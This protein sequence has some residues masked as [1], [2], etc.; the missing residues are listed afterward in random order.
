MARRYPLSRASKA[1]GFIS[2]NYDEY[3]EPMRKTSSLELKDLVVQKFENDFVST[4]S[5]RLDDA[6]IDMANLRA[7]V[8][9]MVIRDPLMV[10]STDLIWSDLWR[11]CRQVYRIDHKVADDLKNTDLDEEIPADVLLR[12]PYPII[13]IEMPITV[14]NG[15]EQFKTDGF[16]AYQGYDNG[17]RSIGLTYFVKDGGRIHSSIPCSKTISL[18]DAI[19]HKTAI[20]EDDGTISPYRD[21]LENTEEYGCIASQLAETI[22][23]LLYIIAGNDLETV[24]TPPK[25]T[26]PGQKRGRKTNPETVAIAGA[27]MGRAIKST[28]RRASS[29]G[30]SEPT[31]QT[32][33]PHIR[34]AHWAHYWVGPRKDRSDGKPGDRLELKW[35]PPINVNEDHGEV[36]ETIHR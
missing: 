2:S 35:I 17:I 19:A 7:E 16:L 12:I 31:G 27:K 6:Q 25:T 11:S 33:A 24:Y 20:V 22:N 34:A 15:T 3:L 9:K 28:K 29:R 23:A 5:H 8:S 1:Y 4:V 14:L 30:T 32:K 10:T 13:Y 26:K 36:V 21:G 18:R